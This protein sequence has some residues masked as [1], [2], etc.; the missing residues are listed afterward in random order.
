MDAF[1]T[2]TGL[3]ALAE[4][5]DKTQLLAIILATR[6]KKPWPIVWGILLATLLNH[7]L[8][9]AV[10]TWVTTLLAP[11]TL[12]W[13][14]VAGFVGMGVWTL[15]PDKQDDNPPDTGK[16]GVFATTVL[17]FFLAEMGDKT[18]LAT[19]AIAAQYSHFLPV[20]LGTTLGMMLANVPVVFM[21]ER[22]TRVLPLRVLRWGASA[23]FFVF[24]GWVAYS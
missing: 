23:L 24:A 7:A 20:V 12:R 11:D 10:G 16:W 3:V 4:M 19:V 13:I 9:G 8:A 5:G 14:L 18:Q 15:F 21:G 17:V 22:L 1:L 6:F 2:S